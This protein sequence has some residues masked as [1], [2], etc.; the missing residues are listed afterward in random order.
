M[1]RDAKRVAS[2]LL[3]ATATAAGRMRGLLALDEPVAAGLR[4]SARGRLRFGQLLRD[5]Q[6]ELVH[7]HRRLRRRLH[8]EQR[9]LLGVRLRL[10]RA[11]GAQHT[12]GT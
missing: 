2:L 12:W 6:E 11:R 8:E 5:L 3:R 1:G 10:L 4:A 7:V 9:V